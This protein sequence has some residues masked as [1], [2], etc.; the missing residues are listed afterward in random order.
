[1]PESQAPTPLWSI[2]LFPGDE[3]DLAWFYN[4]SG[5][6]LGLRS[7][8]GAQLEAMRARG[9]RNK[10]TKGVWRGDGEV[11]AT[12]ERV[13]SAERYRRIET[14][15]RQLPLPKRRVLQAFYGPGTMLTGPQ[16]HRL[17]AYAPLGALVVLLADRF[18]RGR[19]PLVED[20]VACLRKGP[21]GGEA[22]SRISARKHEAEVA[23]VEACTAYK[24]VCRSERRRPDAGV[25][26]FVDF[27]RT[28]EPTRGQV[29]TR[30]A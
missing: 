16:Q 27:A 3:V 4:D 5:S 17:S 10:G 6:A 2:R 1:M 25:V 22:R 13:E 21:A 29:E 28:V 30:G 20:V 14:R 24:D 18:K 7:N 15:L 9:G 26:T 11:S 19:G 8:M 12:D 23:L